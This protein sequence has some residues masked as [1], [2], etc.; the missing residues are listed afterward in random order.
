M[1]QALKN[2]DDSIVKY[3]PGQPEFEQLVASTLGNAGDS[4]DGFETALAGILA[5]FPDTDGSLAQL[6]SNLADLV[7]AVDDFSSIDTAS[8]AAE[9]LAPL[10]PLAAQLH[11]PQPL[12]PGGIQ[13]PSLPPPCTDPASCP[14]PTAC[15]PAPTG[16]GGTIKPPRRL[17]PL[18]IPVRPDGTPCPPGQGYNTS[19]GKCQPLCP[20]GY[21]FTSDGQCQPSTV[22]S[23]GV[24]PKTPITLPP[25]PAG[26]PP[27]PQGF[28]SDGS[29]GCVDLSG[30]DLEAKVLLVLG[31]GL[32]SLTSK[33][34]TPTTAAWVSTFTGLS[35]STSFLIVTAIIG[36]SALLIE[37]LGG[38]CGSACVEASEIEQVYEAIG[39]DL[40]RVAKA[41]MIG[42]AEAVVAITHF[43][44]VG[45]QALTRVGT[46][47]ATAGKQNM[48]NVMANLIAKARQLPSTATVP[49][50]LAAAKKF[51]VGG[52]GWYP[53]SITVA[54]KVTTQFLTALAQPSSA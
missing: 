18:P 17:P 46:D 1:P 15:F 28:V 45:D 37:I 6:D 30:S 3:T 39:D 38:G 42:G 25:I 40:L 48:D 29:S 20:P 31:E 16:G 43:M 34:V 36:V 22:Y 5:L 54:D 33:E 21:N 8:W 13:L 49:L 52:A 27:C 51:Y 9:A 32:L 23:T 19:T 7:A 41:G 50:D 4:S 24:P 35:L 26:L 14:P 12:E 47:Q 10:P 44:G 11:A 2:I 53:T